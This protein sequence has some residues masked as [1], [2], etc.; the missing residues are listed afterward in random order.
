MCVV[1]YADQQRVSSY[2][3]E[4]WGLST[5]LVSCNFSGAK[6]MEMTLGFRKICV[7]SPSY[8]YIYICLNEFEMINDDAIS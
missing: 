5:E 2:S 1:S 8:I 7:P 3:P 4:L 6:N